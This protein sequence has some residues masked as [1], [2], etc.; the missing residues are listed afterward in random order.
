MQVELLVTLKVANGT[1]IPAHTVYSDENGQAIPDFVMRRL[2]R[3]MARIIAGPSRPPIPTKPKVGV[4][5]E[6]VPK[7]VL[8]APPLK[9]PEKTV[10]APTPSVGQEKAAPSGI[11]TLDQ[12][13]KK[14]VAPV[15]KKGIVKKAV[16]K[17]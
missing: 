4:V 11:E 10:V 15:K 14:T 6:S 13:E 12:A 8:Q 2:N 16:V 9:V 1:F 7:A 3:G 5:Q 17:K